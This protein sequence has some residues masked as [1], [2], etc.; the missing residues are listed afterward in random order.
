MS[1]KKLNSKASQKRLADFLN[2]IGDNLYAL[3]ITREETLKAVAKAV[4]MPA[5][6]LSR[7]EKGLCPNCRMLTLISLCKY[8]KVNLLDVVSKGKFKVGKVKSK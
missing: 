4:K 6:R 8:Y 2:T 1:R 3:R 5:V 7:I